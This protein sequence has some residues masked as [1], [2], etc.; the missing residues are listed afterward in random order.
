MTM[1]ADSDEDTAQPPWHAAFIRALVQTTSPLAPPCIHAS[2]LTLMLRQLFLALLHVNSILSALASNTPSLAL[3]PSAALSLVIYV[4]LRACA[5]RHCEAQEDGARASR[6]EVDDVVE[7]AQALLGTLRRCAVLYV[8]RF[9]PSAKG[10]SC[11][12][13]RDIMLC[14]VLSHKMLSLVHSM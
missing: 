2:L 7:E 1:L 4:D 10:R 3:S 11:R 14:N 12:L 8:E 9:A 13:F 6:G 5:V